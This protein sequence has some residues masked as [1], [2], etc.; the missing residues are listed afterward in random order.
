MIKDRFGATRADHIASYAR[1]YARIHVVHHKTHPITA[2]LMEAK[3]TSRLPCAY[4]FFV[5]Q[6]A[7]PTCYYSARSLEVARRQMELLWTQY[8]KQCAAKAARHAERAAARAAAVNPYKV[9]DI[10]YS[11]W[12]YEQTNVE[13][14]E[15][16]DVRD[17]S[18]C[19]RQLRT[20]VKETGFMSGDSYPLPGEFIEGEDGAPVWKRVVVSGT[21]D[22]PYY[23]V[24]SPIHGTLSKDDGSLRKNCSWYA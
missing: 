9:G 19:L 20:I 24:N 12:G 22:K 3:T 14:F 13:W 5:G 8:E 1:T 2:V 4:A 16:V 15:V 21:A 17:M 10:L 18:V 23:T 6:A 11:S 7:K